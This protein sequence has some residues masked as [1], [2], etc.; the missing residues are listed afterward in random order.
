MSWGKA[1]LDAVVVAVVVLTFT[2]PASAVEGKGFNVPIRGR[3]TVRWGRTIIGVFTTP[4]V[5]ARA[6]RSPSSSASSLSSPT[7]LHIRK[8]SWW[9]PGLSEP[10]PG[11]LAGQARSR[12][13]NMS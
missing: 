7:Q 12:A 5:N 11:L 4:C 10:H 9:W 1:F 8:S 2:I 3:L 6:S 13:T